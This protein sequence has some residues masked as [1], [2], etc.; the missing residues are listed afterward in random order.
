MKAYIVIN[1]R[2]VD[3]DLLEA[4][5]AGA[6][7]TIAKHGGV[8]LAGSNDATVL[9]GEP[10]GQRVVVVEFPSREVATAWCDD[11]EYQSAKA[12][13]RRATAGVALLVDGRS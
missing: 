13:R 1:A 4:Y 8:V 5:R 6:R 11:P 9:D 3:H 12:L 7:A 10:A 2:V